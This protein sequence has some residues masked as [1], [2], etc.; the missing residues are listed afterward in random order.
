ML[1]NALESFLKMNSTNY[2][3]VNGINA[4]VLYYY[5]NKSSKSPEFHDKL[6]NFSIDLKGNSQKLK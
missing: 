6:F 3:L 2:N 1:N 4:V 5:F